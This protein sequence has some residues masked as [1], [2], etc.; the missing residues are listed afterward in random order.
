[1]V[2]PNRYPFEPPQLKFTTPIYHPN[3]DN[4]GRICLDLLKMPPQGGWKPSINL[5]TILLS[6]RLLLSEANPDD[7]VMP[8]ISE[9]Y[10]HHP[11][12]FN[13][14]A[15]DWTYK[16]AMGHTVQVRT[17]D[18]T[19]TATE[20]SQR[21]TSSS[22]AV[23]SDT[24]KDESTMEPTDPTRPDKITSPHKTESDETT[25]LGKRGHEENALSSSGSSKKR[26]RLKSKPSETD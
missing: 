23:T 10:K 2:V 22:T 7:G 18:A 11:S 17:E 8:E 14:K 16:H 24:P 26:L 1:M 19:T 5:S 13:Q 20:V 3:I 9:E 15:A 4:V 25:S 12:L 6:V 21:A